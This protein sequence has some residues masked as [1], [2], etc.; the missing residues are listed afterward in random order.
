MVGSSLSSYLS[1]LRGPEH[2]ELTEF[3]RGVLLLSRAH[4]A[5]PRTVLTA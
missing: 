2:G 5:N 3:G 4:S 1:V